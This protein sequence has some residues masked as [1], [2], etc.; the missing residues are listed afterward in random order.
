[1]TVQRHTVTWVL[2]Q[3]SQKRR[4]HTLRFRCSCFVCDK[5]KKR[6][7][8]LGYFIILCC[9]R[10]SRAVLSIKYIYNY[11]RLTFVIY[12]AVG[13]AVTVLVFSFRWFEIADFGVR[14][15]CL[16]NF[17]TKSNTLVFVLIKNF[18]SDGAFA[19]NLSP[20]SWHAQHNSAYSPNVLCVIYVHY[21]R[22]TMCCRAHRTNVICRTL[23]RLYCSVL[24]FRKCFRL[25]IASYLILWNYSSFGGWFKQ[26]EYWITSD[27]LCL[28]F[29]DPWRSLVITNTAF[30]SLSLSFLFNDLLPN[31]FIRL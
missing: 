11:I 12:F 8:I 18:H 30:F 5:R 4:P 22:C 21:G 1:M 17:Y 3:L 23:M 15:V 14:F 16:R 6:P 28:F 29:C 19:A 2:L 13:A 25:N 9:G 20:R 27:A 7:N 31:H 26:K 24:P 10:S